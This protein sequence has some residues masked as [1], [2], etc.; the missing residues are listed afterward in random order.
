MTSLLILFLGAILV[1]YFGI[2]KPEKKSMGITVLLLIASILFLV[3]EGFDYIHKNIPAW[4]TKLVPVNM[5]IWDPIA[6]AFSIIIVFSFL[7]VIGLFSRNNNIGADLLGL[8]LFS[9]CGG[10]LM[11]SFS[12]LIML[13]LGIECLSI[14]L[15]VLAGSKKSDLAS[16]ESAVKYFLMGAFSTAIFLMGCAFIYGGTGSLELESISRSLAMFGHM[17]VKSNLIF[18]GIMLL[19]AGMLFKVSAF[20]FHFWSPDV[21]EGSPNRTTV[22]MATVVKIAAFAAFFRL[23]NY[24]FLYVNS[25]WSMTMAISAAATI[26]FGNIAAIRQTSFKRTLAYSSVAHAGYMLMAI[27]AAPVDGFWALLVYLLAYACSAVVIFYLLDRTAEGKSDFAFENFN[28]LGKTN[29]WSSL[30]L[31]VSIFSMAGIP[32]TA[33]FAGKYG[34]FSGIVSNYPWLLTIA[35]V[36]SAISIAY[37]FRVFKNAFF[38]SG[39]NGIK[40]EIGIAEVIFLALALAVTLLVGCWPAVITSLQIIPA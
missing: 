6:V 30:L 4:Q 36:G 37:Y 26:L 17:G 40:L 34:L 16:N 33:G 28:G 20:P 32:L 3:K 8:M 10:M 21:Y 39:D 5:L 29:K 18:A 27:L 19:M 9:V 11:T 1:L 23:F 24:A 12:N 38:S 25:W 14:P 31:V 2:R 15:Y 35:L 22:F 7:L 13:F